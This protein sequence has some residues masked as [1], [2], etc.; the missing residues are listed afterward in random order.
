M[1][2]LLAVTLVATGLRSAEEKRATVYAPRV[3]YTL[4]V[5]EHGNDDYV[6]LPQAVE[7]LGRVSARV[8]D[9]E[10]RLRFNHVECTFQPG[11]THGRIGRQRIDLTAPFLLDGQHGLIPLHSLPVLLSRLLDSRVDFHTASRRIFVGHT[12]TR[13]TVE[14]KKGEGMVLSFSEAVNPTIST[15]PG[16]LR[17]T[18][19]REPIVSDTGTFQ[20]MDEKLTPGAH[21]TESNGTAEV[22][23]QANAP[24]MATFADGGKTIRIIPAPQQAA[25]APPPAPPPPA[26]TP[27]VP[28]AESAPGAQL[29][30]PGAAAGMAAAAGHPAYLVVVDA[31]HGGEE[32][33]ATLSDKLVEKDVT[34]AFARKLRGELQA[35]GINTLMLRDSDA[36]VSLEQRADTVNAA[37]AAVYVALHAAT[38]GT[39]VRVYTAM[40]PAASAQQRLFVPW[41][42]AQS[43]HTVA[44]RALANAVAEEIGKR[45]MPSAVVAAP[46]RPLNNLTAAAIAVE[47]SVPASQ[48]DTL[49]SAN[50]QQQVA[51]A[52]ASGIAGARAV[53]EAAK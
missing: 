45:D 9:H 33:G 53:V 38:L 39:G 16:K 41:E 14:V 29:P 31:G 51:G 42:M 50:Y 25:Q 36:A 10:F 21:F 28:A 37:R 30:S 15:E 47:V 49:N 40:L 12:A 18:F 8:D 4:P 43:G 3:S 2:A 52:I 46:V 32:R 5:Q 1:A 19:T 35:R 22:T 34:L 11:Q 6:S 48:V 17:M 23:V 7:P 13:F 26:A 27:Q 44:S 24:V 20:F